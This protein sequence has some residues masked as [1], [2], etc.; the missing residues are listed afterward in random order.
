M[1][2]ENTLK[3]IADALE[4]IA[5]KVTGR[6][7]EDVAHAA[8]DVDPVVVKDTPSKPGK[9]TP[10]KGKPKAEKKAAA[11]GKDEGPT[12]KDVRAVLV[13]LGEA[14]DSKTS[15]KALKKFKVATISQLEPEK[16][17]DVIGYVEG[18]IAE[19]S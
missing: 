10:R 18:L 9:A 6:E 7:Y 15:R 1:S 3:R 19:A 14:T 17:A 8:E 12:H 2:I 4:D 5:E 11:N 16:Y 13:A